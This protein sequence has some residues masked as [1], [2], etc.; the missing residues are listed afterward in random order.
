M[1]TVEMGFRKAVYMQSIYFCKAECLACGFFFYHKLNFSV[2]IK[3]FAHVDP[4][5][6]KRNLVCKSHR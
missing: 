3:V 5:K 1:Y 4:F 6:M 2:L